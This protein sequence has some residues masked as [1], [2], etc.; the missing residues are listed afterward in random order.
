MA[1]GQA[2][3]DLANLDP[4]SPALLGQQQLLRTADGRIFAARISRLA[5]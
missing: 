1:G 4:G 3:A 5:Q 2:Q